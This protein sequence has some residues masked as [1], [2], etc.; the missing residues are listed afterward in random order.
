MS[1]ASHP[2]RFCTVKDVADRLSVC[3]R[4]I[5]RAIKAGDLPAIRVGRQLRISEEALRDYLE[6]RRSYQPL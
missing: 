1:P 6:R 2:L 5:L 3:E 4:T